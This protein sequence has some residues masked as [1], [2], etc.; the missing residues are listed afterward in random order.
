MEVFLGILKRERYY[1]KRFTDKESLVKRIEDYIDYYNNK[2]LQRNIRVLIP[3]EMK[4]TYKPHKNFQQI[5]ST[6]RKNLC[7]FNCLLDGG[8]SSD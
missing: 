8:S 7:F 3:M 2:H 4:F 5:L 1:G 6:G